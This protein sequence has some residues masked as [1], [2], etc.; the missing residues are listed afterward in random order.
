MNRYPRNIAVNIKSF[1]AEELGTFLARCLLPLIYRRVDDK[2]YRALQRLVFSITKAV[3]IELSHDEIDEIEY[4]MDEFL[5]WFYATFHKG[6]TANLSACKYT[7]RALSHLVQN[8]R[9][10]GP[11]SYYWQYSEVLL[12][13]SK[14]IEGTAVLH[15]CWKR[16]KSSLGFHF[17][18]SRNPP[19]RIWVKK[20]WSSR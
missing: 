16:Q 2:T 18:D 17:F 5:K 9:D 15:S 10:W 7:I 6:K 13:A 12:V 3:G 11:A 14:L 8:L 1:K 19:S 20:V 4:Q